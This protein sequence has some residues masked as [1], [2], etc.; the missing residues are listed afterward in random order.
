VYYLTPERILRIN[1]KVLGGEPAL[2]DWGLLDSAANR[3]MAAMF[4]E[5][6]YPTVT[7]KA[8]AL[9]HWRSIIRLWM[10]INELLPLP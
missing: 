8:A 3:P 10:A 4:G 5:E 7:E 2:R 6:A 9:L 1:G